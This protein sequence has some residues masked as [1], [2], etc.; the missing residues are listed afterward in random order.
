MEKKIGNIF[1]NEKGFGT[2]FIAW[3]L[4]F[5]YDFVLIYFGGHN[6]LIHLKEYYNCPIETKLS[7]FGCFGSVQIWWWSLL[8]KI[9][10]P[11]TATLF[12]MFFISRL[13]RWLNEEYQKEIQKL[14]EEND[15]LIDCNRMQDQIKDRLTPSKGLLNLPIIS[16]KDHLTPSKGLLNPPIIPNII[17]KQN[18]EKDMVEDYYNKKREK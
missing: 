10:I 2:I 14:K 16:I 7:L 6:N 12:M 3:W 18:E 15:I 5:N 4:V 1:G 11:L 9:F 8:W 13:I 17:K